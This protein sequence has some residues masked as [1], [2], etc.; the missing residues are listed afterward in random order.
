[1][2]L[3]F[4][5]GAYGVYKYIKTKFFKVTPEQINLA[6]TN[7]FEK[8]AKRNLLGIKPDE[9]DKLELIEM[10]YSPKS[11]EAF[12]HVKGEHIILLDISFKNSDRKLFEDMCKSASFVMWVDHHASSESFINDNYGTFKKC[13]AHL[14]AVYNTRGVSAAELTYVYLKSIYEYLD[15]Q[16]DPTNA[17]FVVAE[18]IIGEALSKVTEET[19]ETIHKES[20]ELLRL[21]SDGDT[22]AAT[23]YVYPKT[24]LVKNVMDYVKIAIPLHARSFFLDKYVPYETEERRKYIPRFRI[25]DPCTLR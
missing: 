20:T 6:C 15:A 24:I 9:Y 1:M 22:R 25:M 3:Y 17:D 19:T 4:I 5:T 11:F 21:I 18:N 12:K 23:E 10:D 8:V 7:N 16:P 14:G 13:P 2:L